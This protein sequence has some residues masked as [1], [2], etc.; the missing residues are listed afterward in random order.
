[1]KDGDDYDVEFFNNL[2]DIVYGERRPILFAKNDK[3][4]CASMFMYGQ[5]FLDKNPMQEIYEGCSYSKPNL[6]ID[7]ATNKEKSLEST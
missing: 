7:L 1:M 5:F 4:V 3:V 2:S 6:V